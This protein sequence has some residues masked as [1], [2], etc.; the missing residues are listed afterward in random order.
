MRAAYRTAL[1]AGLRPSF[2]LEIQLPGDMV[3]VNVHPAKA[4]VRFHD[5][6]GVERAV[7]R[8]VRRALGVLDSA[9]LVGPLGL[10][11]G[12]HRMSTP[13][14]SAPLT[15]L[16]TSGTTRRSSGQEA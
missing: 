4:E 16:P 8:A 12:T 14:L 10:V 1:A 6:W 13:E 15:T 3:D 5:R 11:S 2:A 7:E 9:A